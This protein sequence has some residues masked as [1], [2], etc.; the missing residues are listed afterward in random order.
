MKNK[1]F[2]HGLSLYLVSFNRENFNFNILKSVTGIMHMRVRWN[3]YKRR[4]GPIQCRNCQSYGHGNLNCHLPSVCSLCGENHQY[5]KCLHLNSYEEGN[6]YSIKCANCKQNHP[7][8]SLQ[9]EKRTE[10]I[11][12]RKKLSYH[13]HNKTHTIQNK[14]NFPELKSLKPA[15]VQNNNYAAEKQQF[16]KL[17]QK[18]INND[19]FSINELMQITHEIITSLRGCINKDDQFQVISKLAVKYVYGS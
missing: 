7:S 11:N 3:T 4:S 2:N 16:S 9:C 1:K 15:S 5:E 18:H 12:I 6:Y 13:A 14:D 8:N 10:F 19:L 17:H